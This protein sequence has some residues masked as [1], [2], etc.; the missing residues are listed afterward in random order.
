MLRHAGRQ[1]GQSA[2]SIPRIAPAPFLAVDYFLRSRTTRRCAL[3]PT[4]GRYHCTL[5]SLHFAMRMPPSSAITKN[6]ME[7]LAPPQGNLRPGDAH[8]R[9]IVPHVD[10]N[11]AVVALDRHRVMAAPEWDPRQGRHSL[12]VCSYCSPDILFY[13]SRTNWE[14]MQLIEMAD[15]YRIAVSTPIVVGLER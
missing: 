12:T 8:Q 4:E 13:G 10:S 3:L 7:L 11:A 2:R 9:H 6:G 15:H 5:F 14:D 1:V